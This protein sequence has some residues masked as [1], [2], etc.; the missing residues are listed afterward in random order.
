MPDD[1]L[2]PFGPAAHPPGE[3]WALCGPDCTALP[4]EPATPTTEPA[5]VPTPA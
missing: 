4:P 3:C 1:V 5:R 2:P